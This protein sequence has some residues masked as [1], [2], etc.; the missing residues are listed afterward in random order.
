VSLSCAMNLCGSEH[1]SHVVKCMCGW[2]PKDTTPL[3]AGQVHG[4][5]AHFNKLKG[6]GPVR[7]PSL[8][9]ALF[10][11]HDK[12]NRVLVLILEITLSPASKVALTERRAQVSLGW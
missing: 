12:E 7:F 6:Q 2:H 3:H 11:D 9:Q 5:S 10:L 4:T 8:S 1:V